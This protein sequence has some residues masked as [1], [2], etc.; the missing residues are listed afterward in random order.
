MSRDYQGKNYPKVHDTCTL[1]KTTILTFSR[2]LLIFISMQKKFD[3]NSNVSLFIFSSTR[4][5]II[6]FHS[7]FN[8]RPMHPLL[9]IHFTLYCIRFGS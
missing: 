2:V 6:T 8:F 3:K 9:G 4:E 5:N 7:K 1:E